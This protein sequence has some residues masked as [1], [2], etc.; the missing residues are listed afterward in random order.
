MVSASWIRTVASQDTP[1]GALANLEELRLRLASRVAFLTAVTT[2]LAMWWALTQEAF[3]LIAFGL[4]AAVLGL[5]LGV[6]TIL[7]GHPALA[8]QLLVWGLTIALLAGMWLFA[9]PWLPFLGLLLPFIGAMLVAGGEF[10]TGGAVTA[11]ALWLAYGGT[12]VYAWPILLVALLLSVALAWVTVRTF[13]T[14]VGW[15]WNTQQRADRL[16]EEARTHRAEASRALKSLETAYAT[17]QRIQREL[18][19]ARQHADEA[20]RMKEQFAANISHEL[21]TPLNLILGFSEVMYLSPEVYGELSWP[22]TLRRDVYQIYRNSRHLLELIDDILDLSRFEMTGFT[23]N[24]ELTPLN[25]LLQ[26]TIEIVE[27]LFRGRPARLEVEINANLPAVEIDRTRIRQVVLNLLKNAQRF[28]EAGSVRLAATYRDDQVVISVSDTGAGIPADKLP[29]IFD[30]FYQADRSLRRSH[31]GAGLGLAISRR[32]VEAHGGRIWAESQEGMGS[33]FFFTLPTVPSLPPPRPSGRNLEELLSPEPRPTILIVDPDPAVASM[34]HR[35]IPDYEVIHIADRTEVDGAI[36]GYHPWTVV[37]NKPPHE[38]QPD[39]H[40]TTLPVPIIMCSLPSQAALAVDFAV[41]AVLTK[42]VMPQQLLR[43]VERLQPVH[44]ILIV[45]NDRGFG[46]LVRRMLATSGQA[47]DIRHA[48]DGADGLLAMRTDRPDA[49]LLDLNMPDVDGF[50]VLAEM[51]REPA[52]A[53]LPVVLL[54]GAGSIEAAS[55]RHTCD[56]MIHRADG[57]RPAEVLRCIHAIGDVLEPRYDQ[58]GT[59]EATVTPHRVGV[60]SPGHLPAGMA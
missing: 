36:R 38:R 41:S 54:T 8:R 28:T 45:D 23:L 57:L 20:R 22:P 42:P 44:R 33:T 39:E 52:I 29:Y 9:N 14:A 24:K 15:A 59:M 53:D 31:E 16:L 32:F 55:T 37:W 58:P 47:F 4:W 19:I 51:R 26:G 10:S 35:H 49:V 34:V 3:P 13:Y 43:A 60:S 21:R 25:P 17:E 40:L 30:E 27:D 11:L 1:Q 46:Q 5:S 50:Q 7:S 12:R 56:I 6:L 2:G 48:Y 18:A